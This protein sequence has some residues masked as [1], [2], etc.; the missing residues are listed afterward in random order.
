MQK[1]RINFLRIKSCKTRVLDIR[2]ELN[3]LNIKL[4]RIIFL[5][6]PS[7]FLSTK[8]QLCRDV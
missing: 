7:G 4:E 6:N 2:H 5:T 3:Q 8:N 1:Y